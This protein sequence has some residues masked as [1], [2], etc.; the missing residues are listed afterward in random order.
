MAAE[1]RYNS[2][3][4][5]YI[6]IDAVASLT[7]RAVYCCMPC[8]ALLLIELPVRQRAAAAPAA[9]AVSMAA[10]TIDL[11]YAWLKGPQD[12]VIE[13]KQLPAELGPHDVWAHTIVSALKIGTDR[14]NFQ[15]PEEGADH[16]PGA[17]DYPRFVGDSNCA[18][19]KAVG[20]EVSHFAVGERIVTRWPHQS[21]YIFNELTGDGVEDRVDQNNF[22]DLSAVL[23]VPPGVA[24]EDAVWAWLWT[25]SQA[26]YQKSLFRPG[27]TVA[28]VGLGT[29]GMG[30]IALGPLMGARVIG[31]ANSEVRADMAR[32]NGAHATFL[33]SDPDLKQKISDFT[34][35]DG[36]DLVILTANPFPAHRT[37]CE[38]VRDNG[39][40]GTYPPRRKRSELILNR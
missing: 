24:A 26:C 14:G 31:I 29:L 9:R 7:V 1:A 37:A 12:L 16:F 4:Y 19:I 11:R 22:G 40:V 39:R 18:I 10:E 6:Y 27:E 25:L 13:T 34:H 3:I 38:I 23:K 21:D 8:M 36:V 30:C 2:D 17:P 5:I 20:S 32:E 15:G 28:V 33:Y 35:G